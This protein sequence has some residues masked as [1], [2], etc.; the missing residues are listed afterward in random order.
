MLLRTLGHEVKGNGSLTAG[1]EVLQ[2]FAAQVGIEATAVKPVDG[3]GLSRQDLVAPRAI[4]KLLEYM[5]ASPRFQ[6][7]LDSLPVSGKDGTLADRFRGPPTGG[8]IHAKTGSM[9]HVNALS[10]YMDLPS[11][12]RLAFAI[13]G[14]N[15]PTKPDQGEAV[16]DRIALVIY[17][18]FAGRRGQK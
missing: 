1:L 3:S 13:I 2:E 17:R 18:H 10:G 8:R 15:H 5:A 12:E 7:F 6:A 9:E 4:T 14:N 16:V 11:G